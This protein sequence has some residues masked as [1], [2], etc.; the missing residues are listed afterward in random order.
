[1][2]FKDF[3]ITLKNISTALDTMMPYLLNTEVMIDVMA[4]H[5]DRIFNRGLN[6]Y[7]NE[8][9]GYSSKESYYS[10]G[11]FIRISA[12]KPQ[13]KKNKGNFKNGKERKSMY[14]ST[15]Y[16]GFRDI[17]GRKTDKVNLKYSGSLERGLNVVKFVDI[18]IYGCTSEKESL[19]LNG[20]ENKYEDVFELS[21]EEKEMMKEKTSDAVAFIIKNNE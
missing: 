4:E 2:D 15:G 5:K 6:S 3:S 7:K 13:G 12:F 21:E 1:M 10:K 11:K 14:I 17:Q 19:K 20:L 16:T 18:I 9:G 8:I